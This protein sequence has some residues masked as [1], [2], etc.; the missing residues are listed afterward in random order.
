MFELKYMEI[1]GFFELVLAELVGGPLDGSY[2][3][4][5]YHCHWGVTSDVGSEH[6]VDG[7]SFAGEVSHKLTSMNVNMKLVMERKV[8]IYFM[9]TANNVGQ[10]VNKK[11]C[12][13]QIFCYIHLKTT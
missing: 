10:T 3:L 9:T 7:S 8:S 4:E 6:T 2:K 5:Q 13:E 12:I 1:Q 11:T